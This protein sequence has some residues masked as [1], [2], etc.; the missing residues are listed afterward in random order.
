M[1]CVPESQFQWEKLHRI[2]V[3]VERGV[4]VMH[5]QRDRDWVKSSGS[6]TV[7]IDADVHLASVKH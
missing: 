3:R 5:T 4:P 6:A 2:V 7:A 1:C